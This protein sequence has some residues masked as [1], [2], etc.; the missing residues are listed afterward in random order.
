MKARFEI[1]IRDEPGNW[2]S[3]LIPRLK[4]F[5]KAALRQYGLRFESI[6]E[7]PQKRTP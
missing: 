5:S 3:P 7:I 6:R 2:Q 4:R 1:V